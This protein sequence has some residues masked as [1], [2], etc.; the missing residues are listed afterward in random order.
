MASLTGDSKAKKT[1]A[2]LGVHTAG[3]DGLHGSSKTGNGAVGVSEDGI[4]VWGG[5]KSSSGVGGMTASGYGVHGV[6]KTGHGVHGDSE[7]GTGVYGRTDAS[8]TSPGQA[9]VFGE[10]FDA[11]AVFGKSQSSTGVGGMSVAGIGVHGVSNPGPGVRGDSENGIGVLASSENGEAVRAVSNSSNV[12]A[13]AVFNNN[14]ASTT[15]ALY[16]KKEGTEG[17]AAFFEGNVAVTRNLILTG[18]DADIILP[19]GDVAEQFE[20]ISRAPAGSVVVLDD[21]AR[22]APCAEPYDRRVAGIVS[23]LGDRKPAVVLDR[24]DGATSR[25]PVAVVGKA[26]CLA[27]AETSPIHVGDLLTTSP[28][29]GH[30]MR[31]LD[32]S[33]AFGAIIGKALTPL[34]SGEGEVLVLVALS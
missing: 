5:S 19:G 22:L 8:P 6:S 12:A 2:V 20:M 13:V 18:P 15:A 11:V 26:W 27:D 7:T 14:S 1:P 30:A 28:R 16:A 29:R 23:G 33:R 3:G 32:G 17:N 31:A 10:A 21:E 4:G 25:Q 24:V 9:G 34:T